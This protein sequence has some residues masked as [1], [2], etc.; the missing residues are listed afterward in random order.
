MVDMAK[1]KPKPSDAPCEIHEVP[2]RWKL[3]GSQQRAM[4]AIEGNDLVVLQGHAGC[5]KSF[6]ALYAAKLALQSNQA[7]KIVVVR[8]P[9]EVSRAKL[10]YLKG[11]VDEKLQP[12]AAASR[13]IAKDLGIPQESLEFIHL[14][15]LQ[16]YTFTNAFVIVEECQSLTL[17]EFEMTVTR[18]GLGSKM[19]MTGDPSQDLARSGGMPLFTKAIR[20][21]DGVAVVHF[22]PNDNQRHAL[23]RDICK[24]IAEASGL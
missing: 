3:N 23:V 18:L 16:G 21:V 1:R 20:N 9:L 7:E 2:R 14:G 11:S 19:V 5:G 6:I 8:S 12:W 17:P 13:S 22:D 4:E 24:A 10:G 15:F